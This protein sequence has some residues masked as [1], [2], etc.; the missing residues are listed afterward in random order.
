[1]KG[2]G[3]AV[4]GERLLVGVPEDARGQ[5]VLAARLGDGGVGELPGG[6]HPAAADRHRALLPVGDARGV[7]GQ[8]R[9]ALAGGAEAAPGLAGAEDEVV[10]GVAVAAR[11]AVLAVVGVADRVLVI[12]LVAAAGEDAALVHLDDV[13]RALAPP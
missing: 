6:V 3:D 13:A 11:H 9:V 10:A 7:D 2:V 12:E 1:G 5:G 4:A 8:P